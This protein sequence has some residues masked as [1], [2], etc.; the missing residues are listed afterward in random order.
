VP[1]PLVG[2]A[3]A[4]ARALTSRGDDQ[5]E[6]GGKRET[7]PTA[8]GD[9]RE[10]GATKTERPEPEPQDEQ[11]EQRE[12]RDRPEQESG[13]KRAPGGQREQQQQQRGDRKGAAPEDT[14]ETVARAREQLEALLDRPIEAV[15][16]LERMR[17]GWIVSLEVV[18]LS[19]IPESTD[20]LATYEMELDNDR[21][22]VRYA[23]VG[24][25]YRSQANQGDQA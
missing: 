11:A 8:A 14:S 12:E 19:R 24:R 9:E 5:G 6:T 10:D 15:S 7:E 16:S 4:A 13:A 1:A 3:A 21:N 2:A 20:V 18:E 25:Y 17:D 22:L 23:R